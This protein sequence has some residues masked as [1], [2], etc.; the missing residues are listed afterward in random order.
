MPG[1]DRFYRSLFPRGIYQLNKFGL[2]QRFHNLIFGQHFVN[3][4]EIF[5]SLLT[6]LALPET[7][8]PKFDASMKKARTSGL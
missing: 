4:I 3:I 8:P 1:R 2:F 5:I 7:L 6:T